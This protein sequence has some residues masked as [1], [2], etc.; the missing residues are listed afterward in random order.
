M[1][2]ENNVIER[3]KLDR[4][5]DRGRIGETWTKKVTFLITEY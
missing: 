3:I 1:S 5:S 2:F 4:T